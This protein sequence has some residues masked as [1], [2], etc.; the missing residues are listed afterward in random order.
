MAGSEAAAERTAW[1]KAA[2][3]QADGTGRGCR[4]GVGK[5]TG[6]LISLQR[7]FCC[8]HLMVWIPPRPKETSASQGHGAPAA[9]L[10]GLV[11]AW[12]ISRPQPKRRNCG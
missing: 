8:E 7:W 6:R 11:W 2:G 12:V 10:M 5:K 4:K 9:G 1:A 3:G